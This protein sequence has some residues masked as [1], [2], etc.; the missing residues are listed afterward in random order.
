MRTTRFFYAMLI[1]LLSAAFFLPSSSAQDYTRWHLP[2]GAIARF[3]KGILM[4]LVYFPDGN[5]LAALSS[6][7]IW[8]YDVRTGEELDILT[9]GSA[10]LSNPKK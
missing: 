3:G 8:I 4:D 2:E 1:F 9:K 5:R 7:G 6:I 10:S